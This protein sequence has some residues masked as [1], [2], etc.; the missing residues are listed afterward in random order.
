M[1]SV[2]K[3]TSYV[4]SFA[5][6]MVLHNGTTQTT[7]LI[8]NPESEYLK[9]LPFHLRSYQDALAYLPNQTYIGN[10]TPEELAQYPQPWYKQKGLARR[11]GPFGELM[12]QEE[13]ILLMQSCDVFDLVKQ[14]KKYVEEAKAHLRQDPA[15]SGEMIEKVQAGVEKSELEYLVNEE[16]AEALYH[17]NTLVGCVKRAHDVDVNLS[18]H[19]I[20][21]N[22]VAKAGNVLAIRH[23][24][25]NSGVDPGEIEYIIDASEEACGDMNQRGG[26]NYAKAAAEIAGMVLIRMLPS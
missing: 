21:E 18:A 25:H 20:L 9:K 24:L 10:V 23:L 26:G 7:E 19:V 14:E 17:Q 11:Y 2:I 15:I 13:F 5:P 4:L 22:L 1:N 12:P 6:D 16:H 3:G 8:V